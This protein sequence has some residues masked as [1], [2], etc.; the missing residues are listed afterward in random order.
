MNSDLIKLL[1]I[2]ESMIAAGEK[3]QA[4]GDR[5]RHKAVGD[6]SYRA[7]QQITTTWEEESH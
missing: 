1:A 4:V 3:L 5:E 6:M 7:L 2:L